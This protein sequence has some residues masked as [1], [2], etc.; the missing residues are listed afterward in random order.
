MIVRYRCSLD[1]SGL[2]WSGVQRVENGNL[3]LGWSQNQT[4]LPPIHIDWLFFLAL[5]LWS[6]LK[7]TLSSH[8][9]HNTGTCVVL[10]YSESK[11]GSLTAPHVSGMFAQDID[12]PWLSFKCDIQCPCN[13]VLESWD[14]LRPIAF[15][16]HLVCW[17]PLNCEEDIYCFLRVM[18]SWINLLHN[19]GHYVGH[20][21]RMSHTCASVTA[22]CRGFCATDSKGQRPHLNVNNMLYVIDMYMAVNSFVWVIHNFRNKSCCPLNTLLA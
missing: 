22:N 1:T 12:Q 11:F 7:H 10:R 8:I 20:T 3:L 2:A 17:L 19:T 6:S 9:L 14:S 15:W 4:R 16:Q 13:A 18:C 5:L 21:T